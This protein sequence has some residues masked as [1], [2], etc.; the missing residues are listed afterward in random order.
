MSARWTSDCA[1]LS[2]K[3]HFPL[4]RVSPSPFF[5]FGLVNV[6]L[7][8]ASPQSCPPPTGA[9]TRLCA[10]SCFLWHSPGHGVC[11]AESNRWP[12]LIELYRKPR[13]TNVKGMSVLWGKEWQLFKAFYASL[14]GSLHSGWLELE[15]PKTMMSDHS[16]YHVSDSDGSQE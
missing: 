10:I 16:R 12:V 2:L 15:K 8:E 1:R 11:R 7:T 3:P 9:L 14:L 13:L 6:F 5:A 4:H